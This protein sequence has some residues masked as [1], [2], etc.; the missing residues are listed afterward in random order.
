MRVEEQRIVTKAAWRLCGLQILC[1]INA[2][3]IGD[4]MQELPTEMA[5]NCPVLL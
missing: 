1:L 4:I 3:L 5:R 2:Y